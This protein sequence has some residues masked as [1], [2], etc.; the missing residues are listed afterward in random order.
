VSGSWFTLL[1]ALGAVPAVVYL[2]LVH[3]VRDPDAEADEYLE[4]VCAED[5]CDRLATHERLEGV[6][7]RGA[8]VVELVCRRHGG[9]PRWH[10]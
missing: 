9:V 6:T 7:C 8:L 10:S 5:G 3:V 1:A 2:V 4:D